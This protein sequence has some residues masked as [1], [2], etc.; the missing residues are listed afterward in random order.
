MTA[1]SIRRVPA[2]AHVA[3]EA[4]GQGRIHKKR[5]ILGTSWYFLAALSAYYSLVILIPFFLGGIYHMSGR[6]M[7]ASSTV[8]AGAPETQ[9]AC[10]SFECLILPILLLSWLDLR[11][12]R[13][14]SSDSERKFKRALLLYS[15]L[16]IIVSILFGHGLYSWGIAVEPP[17]T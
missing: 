1:S 15:V 3:G 12:T 9:V 11:R 17:Y 4:M 2:K 8:T 5:D 10:L 13:L 16:I 7:I 14:T 6:E